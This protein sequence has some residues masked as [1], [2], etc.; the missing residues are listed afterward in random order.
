MIV[1]GGGAIIQYSQHDGIGMP[2]ETGPQ[3]EIVGASIPAATLKHW[4]KNNL[5]RTVYLNYRLESTIE[6]KQG[7]KSRQELREGQ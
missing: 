5:R 4:P 3:R 1:K 6:K 2:G 7:G